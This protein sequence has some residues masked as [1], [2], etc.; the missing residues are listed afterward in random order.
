VID[1][2][3]HTT[4]S[5][6]RSTPDELV[7]EAAAA[8]IRTLA[9]TDHDTLDAVPAVCDAAR[10]AG[11]EPIAGVEITAVEHGRDVHVLGYFIDV[12]DRALNE[13]LAA[14]RLDR[15]RRVFEIAERLDRLGAP[16]DTTAF[17][18]P[19]AASGRSL[20]RPLVAAALVAAGHAVD[21]A[22][23]FDRYLGAGRP[24][25]VERRG[26]SPAE[27]VERLA[28]AGGVAAAAHPG[29]T[30]PDGVIE[31]MIAAGMAAIEVYHPDHDATA[32][33]RYAALAEARGLLMT[34]GSD[35]HGP[36][37]ARAWA[38][39]T[40]SLPAPAFS[41]LAARVRVA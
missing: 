15:R 32:T 29:K 33:A 13:F 20:G 23:A 24:A 9:V 40:V 3:L 30:T 28:A 10:A 37:S 5:D 25:F 41:A 36:G 12:A 26:A 14:Q 6:G 21:I 4:A 22:D 38:F 11:L 1:L 7:R 35:Y 8:G 2:H 27:V 31:Q 18:A 17:T 39:G 34:G 19:A 16:I